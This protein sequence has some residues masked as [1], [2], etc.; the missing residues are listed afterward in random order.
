MCQKGST[1]I[2]RVT[3]STWNARH[4]WNQRGAETVGKKKGDIVVFVFERFG[5]SVEI[6][7]GSRIAGFHVMNEREACENMIEPRAHVERDMKIG[8][9]GMESA[10]ERGCHDTV[11]DP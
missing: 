5:G 2:T 4:I 8:M 1:T 7:D 10:E 9:V 6:H 3:N 11:A